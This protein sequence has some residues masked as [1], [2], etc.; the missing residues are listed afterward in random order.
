[1]EQRRI[2]KNA[3]KAVIGQLHRQKILVENLALRMR[4]SH[5]DELPRSVEPH[6]FVPQR[7]EMAEIAAGSTTEIED[8]I[9]RVALHCIEECR[10]VLAD[11]VMSR[12]VPESPGEP[13][14]I[15]DRRIREALDLLS[16][17]Y[18]VGAA[19]RP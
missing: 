2:C 9:R 17:I 19:H 5:G 6:R 18:F 15:R 4:A 12:A 7:S 16:V 13:I 8:G 11:I 10:V 3:V 1:M 14:V